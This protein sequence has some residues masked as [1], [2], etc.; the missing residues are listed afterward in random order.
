MPRKTVECSVQKLVRGVEGAHTEWQEC[1]SSWDRIQLLRQDPRDVQLKVRGHVPDRSLNKMLGRASNDT[2]FS[3]NSKRLKE[4]IEGLR[5]KL[6]AHI[7]SLRNAQ[8]HV[9]DSLKGNDGKLLTETIDS[10]LRQALDDV[11]EIRELQSDP[12][13]KGPEKGEP[14]D[15]VELKEWVQRCMN[16]LTE[17]IKQ[18]EG[19]NLPGIPQ[20]ESDIFSSKTDRHEWYQRHLDALLR[21]AN[22]HMIESLNGSLRLMQQRVERYVQAA[23][24]ADASDFFNEFNEEDVFEEVLP[25]SASLC[26]SEPV[27]IA[28]TEEVGTSEQG[29]TPTSTD[30]PREST[31]SQTSDSSR[32]TASTLPSARLRGFALNSKGY[33]LRD[34]K[35]A[36]KFWMDREYCELSTDCVHHHPERD[37]Q[38]RLNHKGYPLRPGGVECVFF[39]KNGRCDF[40]ARC[41]K[42]HPMKE[43]ESFLKAFYSCREAAREAV[44]NHASAEG[45]SGPSLG[46]HLEKDPRYKAYKKE[47]GAESLKA[48]LLKMP[49]V[50]HVRQDGQQMVVYARCQCDH[51]GSLKCPST[52]ARLWKLHVNHVRPSLA[53][54][55]HEEQI[56]GFER[57]IKD[58]VPT[59]S[60]DF[61]KSVLHWSTQGDAA[62]DAGHTGGAQAASRGPVSLGG[63][64]RGSLA[65]SQ[66]QRSVVPQGAVDQGTTAGSSSPWQSLPSSTTCAAKAVLVPRGPPSGAAP[67]SPQPPQPMQPRGE[68]TTSMHVPPPPPKQA[69]VARLGA[70]DSTTDPVEQPPRKAPP[71]QKAPPPTQSPAAVSLSPTTVKP[72]RTAGPPPAGSTLAPPTAPLP[73]TPMAPY[74]GAESAM[75]T[76]AATGSSPTPAVAVPPSPES[77]DAAPDA[78]WGAFDAFSGWSTGGTGGTVGLFDAPGIADFGWNSEVVIQMM[79]QQAQLAAE[80]GASDCCHGVGLDG[81][82]SAGFPTGFGCSVTDCADYDGQAAVLSC[83]GGCGG[84]DCGYAHVCSVSLDLP[85]DGSEGKAGDAG[86]AEDDVDS[87]LE[88]MVEDLAGFSLVEDAL[89]KVDAAR[90]ALSKVL[91]ES[92]RHSELR[93]SAPSFVPGQMWTGQQR[94]SFVD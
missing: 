88:A 84:S 36:C 37:P 2:D 80:S 6:A 52:V 27:P 34:G 23:M 69:S 20:H 19:K 89:S 9:S 93:L 87:R 55:R 50:A 7:E 32:G 74:A 78:C 77:S 59:T 61:A 68:T 8:S 43:P 70:Q 86:H 54:A 42:H 49:E 14:D 73:S 53:D 64:G 38:V 4:R 85:A 17:D 63:G 31:T 35:L 79:V 24:E 83:N 44:E 48:T 45:I 91:H 1:K 16:K 21:M 90:E 58:I 39:V 76:F 92:A 57:W 10:W 46:S 13:L 51:L 26:A 62:I 56:K 75:T 82:G 66:R 65:A 3:S 81:T 29:S 22:M 18:M 72:Q 33:P 40:G 41:T 5:K 11:E 47:V 12:R 60:R 30:A 94:S 71:K 67:P 25:A 28:P 15:I